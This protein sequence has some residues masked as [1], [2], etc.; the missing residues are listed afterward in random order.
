VD[1]DLTTLN[2]KITL[3]KESHVYG[4]II[5][6]ENKRESRK[7]LSIEILNGSVL[8]GD[9]IVKDKKRPVKVHI[10]G[11]SK[12]EGKIENAEVIRE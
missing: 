10:S 1:N 3:D 5:I 11:D 6:R 2:G 7:P 12:V 8:Q 4:D 9:I